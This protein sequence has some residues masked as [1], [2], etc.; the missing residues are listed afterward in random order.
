MMESTAI[1]EVSD[2]FPLDE[3]GGKAWF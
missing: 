2:L 1:F 3:D